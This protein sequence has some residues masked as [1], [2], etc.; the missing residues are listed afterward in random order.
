MRVVLPLSADPIHLGHLDII[1]RS[2]ELFDYVFVILATNPKKN[3]MFTDDEKFE[4]CQS[5]CE[6]FKNVAIIEHTNG[7]IVDLCRNLQVNAMVRGFR[8]GADIDHEMTLA[9][10]NKVLN[11][12][13]ETLFLASRPEHTFVSSSIIRE[14][15]SLKKY[16]VLDKY[17]PKPVFE[18]IL[19]KK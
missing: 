4:L 7:T 9:N 11:P 12:R 6:H 13:V 19:K 17:V 3:Y 8:T 16:D 18:Y 15:I 5:S 2:S 14:L 1:T 10:T